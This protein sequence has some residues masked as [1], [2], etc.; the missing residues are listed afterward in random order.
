MLVKYPF[1]ARVCGKEQIRKPGTGVTFGLKR[2]TGTEERIRGAGGG[3]RGSEADIREQ[4]TSV[5]QVSVGGRDIEWWVRTGRWLLLQVR[6]CSGDASQRVTASSVNQPSP[7]SYAKRIANLGRSLC[8]RRFQSPFRQ[9]LSRIQVQ[10]AVFYLHA[11]SQPV[12]QRE[13]P[14]HCASQA[15]LHV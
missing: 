10:Y 3:R 14:L 11:C 15:V 4:F 6:L 7:D 2:A 13:K 1:P 8:E 12:F 5:V 9:L